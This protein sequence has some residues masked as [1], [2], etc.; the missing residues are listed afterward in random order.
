MT[1]QKTAIWDFISLRLEAKED[2]LIIIVAET[3]GHAPGKTG[4][5]M[6]VGLSGE[7]LGTIGGGKVENDLKIQALE[8]YHLNRS[9]PIMIEYTFDHE[10]SEESEGMICGGRQIFLIFRLGRSHLDQIRTIGRAVQ[11]HKKARFIWSQSGEIGIVEGIDESQTMERP[12]FQRGS[13]WQFTETNGSEP[14]IHIIGGGHVSLALSRVLQTLGYHLRVYCQRPE[15]P[16][17]LANIYANEIKIGPFDQVHRL[18]E[19]SGNDYI[20][21]MTPGHKS[22]EL[23]LQNVL[24]LPV[25]FIGMMASPAKSRAIRQRLLDSGL[26]QQLCEKVHSPIGLRINS[27]SPEEIAISVAAQIISIQN[28][29]K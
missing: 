4:A 15:A 27:H 3:H 19:P 5:K 12:V 16:T 26:N 8:Y 29:N 7:T 18:I 1:I 23:V 28:G 9:F 24:R 22:D 21:I 14:T 6:A 2:V 10:I 13:S 17:L 11:H 25:K 20:V